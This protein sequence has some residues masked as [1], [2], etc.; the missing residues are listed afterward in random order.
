MYP[1]SVALE[2]AIAARTAG[3]P[4]AVLI[5]SGHNEGLIRAA[6]GTGAPYEPNCI[7][8]RSAIVRDVLVAVR[9]RRL[10]DRDRSLAAYE[11][12]L[13]RTIETAQASGLTPILTTLPS[14]ISRIEPNPD[15]SG[16]DPAAA[17]VVAGLE[18]EAQGRHA[19]ALAL[20][21]GRFADFPTS[22]ALRYRSGRCAEA[23][24][25]NVSPAQCKIF[26]LRYAGARSV[27]SIA[28]ETGRSAGAVRI[29]LLRSR[30]ALEEQAAEVEE[31][32]AS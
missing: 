9:R 23:L 2:R 21:R 10:V 11:H 12:Y 8:E 5:M 19:E 31:L 13:R 30:R 16:S 24:E 14:N 3:A 28:S 26:A 17:V 6:D 25:R 32:L 27:A 7:A 1:Q 20:Y 22:A 18:L 15:D 4:G 29:G